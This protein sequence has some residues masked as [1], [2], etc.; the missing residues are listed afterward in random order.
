MSR[1]ISDSDEC[2]DKKDGYNG[3]LISPDEMGFLSKETFPISYIKYIK[4]EDWYIALAK[5]FPE[6]KNTKKGEKAK[7]L[8]YLQ[9]KAIDAVKFCN[10]NF[11]QSKMNGS[12]NQWIVKPGGLSRGRNIQIFNNFHGILAYTDMAPINGT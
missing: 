9:L 3:V 7:S 5:E 8:E 10:T 12:Q 4:K 6:V 11:P 1:K 2:I